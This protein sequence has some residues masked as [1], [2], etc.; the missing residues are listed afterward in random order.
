M[1]GGPPRGVPPSDDD[2]LDWDTLELIE[3][4]ESG[5]LD[6]PERE[7]VRRRLEED[8]GLAGALEFVRAN[9][10]IEHRLRSTCV[11][12]P[13]EPGSSPIPE[14][15]GY[16]VSR[17]IHRGGQGIVYA[18]VQ[19]STGRD[20]A[21]KVLLRGELASPRQR[22]RFE[23]EI[24]LLSLLD[25][26]GI[27]TVF[28][29]AMTADGRTALVMELIRGRPIDW[30]VRARSLTPP[31][32]LDLFAGLADV[33][34]AA[35][36]RGV[37]HR[38]L[39]PG[40]VLVEDSGRVR[41]LD[42]GLAKPIE[43]Q[44]GGATLEGEFMGT[45]VYAAPEQF[46]HGS[47]AA[48]V[49]TDVYALG[50][51]LYEALAGRPPID[52]GGPIGVAIERIRGRRPAGLSESGVVLGRDAETVVMT[53]LEKDPDR[54]Y[55]S[56][57]AL[58]ADLRRCLRDEPIAARPP[59]AAYLLG[60]FARRNPWI[61]ASAGIAAAAL[62]AISATVSVALVRTSSA[63]RDTAEA[64]RLAEIEGDKQA[65][66]S[67]FLRDVLTSVDPGRSGPEMRVT[68]L[69]EGVSARIPGEF[70]DY[71][72]LRAGLHSTVAETAWRLGDVD[73]AAEQAGLAISL[74]Q[75]EPGSRRDLAAALTLMA[76]VHLTAQRHAEAEAALEEAERLVREG[77]VG[78]A[79]LSSKVM[80]NR[81][82]SELQAG[83]AEAAAG[84]F[85]R[86]VAELDGVASLDAIRLRLQAMVSGGVALNRLDR[87]AE[88]LAMY[89][90][91]LPLLIET[92]GPEH[93]DTL[94][95]RTNRAQVLWDV[96]RAEE[97]L[98]EMRDLVE[99]RRRVFGPDH[100]RVAVAVNNLADALRRL[101]RFDEAGPMYEEAARIYRSAL[102]EE[103]MRVASVTYNLGV[104]LLESGRAEE[105]VGPL[106][107]AATLAATLL[108]EGHWMTAL[109]DL[110]NGEA[111]LGLGRR[112]AAV[113]L[114]RSA[115][116]RLHAALGEG[117]SR[118]EQA[119]TLLEAAEGAE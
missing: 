91:A 70:A 38:D 10:E 37:I 85:A 119:R 1:S 5:E 42:F 81:A 49:R 34:A 66:V 111:L 26:P 13:S 48:D 53:A 65:R 67:G 12:E 23:R 43:D 99:V 114:I 72:A 100:E 79:L 46:E 98:D 58:A 51:M 83:R 64:L 30:Y 109:F 80:V 15:E 21:I 2:R 92:R 95:C 73:R 27:V 61:V 16:E 93:P 112:G 8:P 4:Y 59:S 97:A 22:Q 105:A 103:N 29:R 89:E 102:G 9:R 62:V 17:E 78:D 57:A 115:H 71:P 33:V 39:K 36:Q 41:V 104:M 63:R 31:E 47:G 60:K 56:A 75:D 20:V 113:E 76:G 52:A 68:E 55:D 94:A 69:L 107:S 45:L 77:G 18:G 118:T 108:P 88:A 6:A 35:H 44:A 106:A 74:L 96:G 50:A 116:D 54:R 11:D 40:N 32:T 3:R 28:D 101:E 87:P 110:R 19:R 82:A 24:G 14:I 25:H 117:H 90:E 86:A 7:S 84:L